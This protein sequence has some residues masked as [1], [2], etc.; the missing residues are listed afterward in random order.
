MSVE[1]CAKEIEDWLGKKLTPRSREVLR[2]IIRRHLAQPCVDVEALAVAFQD[3]WPI[4]SHKA[5]TDIIR[6]HTLDAATVRAEER[7]RCAAECDGEQLDN[8]RM[9][10]SVEGDAGTA[11]LRWAAARDVAMRCA[12]RIRALAPKER[13]D[14]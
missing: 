10:K 14:A 8:A 11:W 9:A 2:V 12:T 1:A 5:V 6:S 3:A 4:G 7:E 13:S